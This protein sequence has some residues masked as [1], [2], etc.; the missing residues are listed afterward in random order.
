[1][2]KL[3][4]NVEI[5]AILHLHAISQNEMG[6][7]RRIS[8]DLEDECFRQKIFYK[9]FNI[10][11]REDFFELM[12]DINEEI[13]NGMRPI[14]HIDAHGS[15]NDG[16]HIPDSDEFVTWNEFFNSI[17][18]LNNTTNNNL[19]VFMGVCFALELYKNI[20]LN[21][22]SP[23]NTLIA[24]EKEVYVSF[25]ESKAYN[26][27]KDL[28]THNSISKSFTDNLSKEMKSINSTEMFFK[29]YKHYIK[30]YCTEEQIINRAR[31][32]VNTKMKIIDEETKNKKIAEAITHLTPSQEQ[33][34]N[35]SKKFLCGKPALFRISD[36][37][38]NKTE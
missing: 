13:E 6:A 26:F 14:I 32:L 20:R 4:D 27:Y 22:A 29:G 30:N 33:I 12:K 24:P 31:N 28:I 18:T 36:I 5:N 11:S 19:I 25:L 17:S 2:T 21:K 7:V 15:Q 37:T 16:I 8:E 35:L 23:A 9:D 3:T 38:S 1:M 10:K 34:D